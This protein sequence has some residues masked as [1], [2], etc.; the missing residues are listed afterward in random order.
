MISKYVVEC[1]FCEENR[2][3]R[4]AIVTVPA[5]SHA[6]AIQKVRTECKRRFGKTLLLQTKITEELFLHKKES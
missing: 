4:Q 2:K 5:T 1:V 6:L 3:P